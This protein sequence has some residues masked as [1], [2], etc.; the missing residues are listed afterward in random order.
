MFTE[1]VVVRFRVLLEQKKDVNNVVE[2]EDMLLFHMRVLHNSYKDKGAKLL[3]T[4]QS[5]LDL[6]LAWA[7][8]FQLS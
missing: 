6:N 5:P 2:M 8:H 4:G 7:L 1:I 3:D